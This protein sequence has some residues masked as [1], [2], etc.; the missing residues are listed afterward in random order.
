MASTWRFEER[1]GDAASLHLGWPSVEADPT[2]RAVSVCTVTAP[3]LVLGSTQPDAAV[4]GDRAAGRGISVVRRRSGGGAVLVTAAD[5][6]WIDAWL[7]AGDP[8]WSDDVGRAFDWLGDTWVEAL[9]RVGIRGLSAHGQGYQACT[10][11]SATVCFGGVG[12][13]EVVTGDGRKVVGLAQRRSRNGA[14]FHGACFIRWDPAPLV[15]LLAWPALERARAIAGLQAAAAGV[16]D[17]AGEAGRP[18]PDAGGV[19][20]ALIGALP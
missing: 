8:L 18:A 7:P 4:D 6:V 5:P 14:W 17:L 16:A 9:T 3:A 11:W 13:G 1:A 10:P 20:G 2:T 15:E 12:S 19:V